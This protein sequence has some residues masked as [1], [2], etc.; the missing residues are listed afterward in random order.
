MKKCVYRLLVIFFVFNSSCSDVKIGNLLTSWYLV[1]VIDIETNSNVFIESCDQITFKQNGEYR[2]E[3][4]VNKEGHYSISN[5][6]L[7]LDRNDT[8][9]ILQ[10]DKDLLIC[11]MK[12]IEGNSTKFIFGHSCDASILKNNNENVQ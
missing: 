12:T 9:K 4:I 8:L 3:T 2:S 7:I 11:T 10:L 5:N 6:Y 1:E